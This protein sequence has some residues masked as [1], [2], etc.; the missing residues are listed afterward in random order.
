MNLGKRVVAQ[1]E[2]LA[3]KGPKQID[4][5]ILNSTEQQG[6]IVGVPG[7]VQEPSAA[8]T[9]DAYDR[10]SVALRHME[11]S[12]DYLPGQTGDEAYLRHCVEQVIRRLTYLEEPLDLLEFDTTN[13]L[14]QVRSASP[15]RDGQSL[16]Y[17]EALIWASP[18]PRARLARYSWQPDSRDRRQIVYP[19]TFA[20]LGRIAQDLALSLIRE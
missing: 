5:V 10:F 13:K 19:A 20:A 14:A 18:H 16:T 15:Y 3:G 17:W 6:Y 12:Y 1:L 2:Q 4:A 11:V 7:E 8:I 9:I